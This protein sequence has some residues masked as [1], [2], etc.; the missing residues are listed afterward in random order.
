MT[1]KDNAGDFLTRARSLLVN[2]KEALQRHLAVYKKRIETEQQD[3][4]SQYENAARL[5]RKLSSIA[6]ELHLDSG[7]YNLFFECGVY[8]AYQNEDDFEFTVD[9]SDFTEI[10]G[11]EFTYHGNQFKLTKAEREPYSSTYDDSLSSSRYETYS[12]IENG[13]LVFEV[14][15]YV[16][17]DIDNIYNG[18]FDVNRQIKL[19]DITA[20]KYKGE[21]ICLL[22]DVNMAK[23]TREEEAKIGFTQ[24]PNIII[25]N[26]EDK[27]D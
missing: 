4:D 20:F 5:K 22:I 26:F 7:L 2:A 21:W 8:S 27:L 17:I 1:I 13:E 10:E 11:Y 18:Y 16:T 14:R 9:I 19:D 15:F 3:I 23:K 6:A 12:L 24:T 25:D